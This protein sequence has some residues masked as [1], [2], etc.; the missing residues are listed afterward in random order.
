MA[1]ERPSAGMKAAKITAPMA[2]VTLN[3]MS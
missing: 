1:G 3:I 2:Y